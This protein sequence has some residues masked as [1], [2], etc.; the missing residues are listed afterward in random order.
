MVMYGSLPR[1]Y[2]FGMESNGV[3]GICLW[4]L[5]WLKRIPFVC[6]RLLSTLK[7]GVYV[8]VSSMHAQVERIRDG[9]LLW[10]FLALD[11]IWTDRC[12]VSG[13]TARRKLRLEMEGRI[14]SAMPRRIPRYEYMSC[15][16]RHSS[17]R[18]LTMWYNQCMKS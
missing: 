15:L 9:C 10:L 3:H 4:L 17:R 11:R 18:K 8:W 13:A 6:F 16:P 12:M 14:K 7:F 1:K 5:L 2:G